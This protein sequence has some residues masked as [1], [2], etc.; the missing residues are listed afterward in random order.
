MKPTFDDLY[1]IISS[2][3]TVRVLSVPKITVMGQFLFKLALKKWRI[4]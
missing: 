1:R 2:Y 3:H 4:K